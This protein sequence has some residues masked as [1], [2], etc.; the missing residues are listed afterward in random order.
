MKRFKIVRKEKI[1][2]LEKNDFRWKNVFFSELESNRL[3]M[4]HI[5]GLN[6]KLTE[7][8]TELEKELC[9]YR[10]KYSEL[11]IKEFEFKKDAMLDIE[12]LNEMLTHEIRELKENRLHNLDIYDKI[13]TDEM[14]EKLKEEVEEVKFELITNASKDSLAS[15]LLDVMQCCVGIARTKDIDLFKHIKKHNKKLKKRGHKFI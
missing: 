1:K 13:S 2:D 11:Q 5:I 12:Y 15:E 9:S 7:R 8:V 10:N 3:A 4:E 6:N 14:F